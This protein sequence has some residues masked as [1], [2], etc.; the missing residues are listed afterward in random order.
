MDSAPNITGSFIADIR[1]AYG[2]KGCF[3][4]ENGL[5]Q[6]FS[7]SKDNRSGLVCL[8]ASRSNSTYDRRD[9]VAPVNYTIRIWKRV[10]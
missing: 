9:E 10:R 3:Y 4:Y 6:D 5:I 8:D 7:D 2:I 1:V